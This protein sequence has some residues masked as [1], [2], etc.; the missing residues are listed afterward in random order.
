MIA[1][2]PEAG[3]AGMLAGLRRA[4]YTVEQ[5]GNFAVFDYL[6]E[7]GPQAGTT[8]RIGLEL[9][10]D[11]P[12]S[13]PH[14]PHIAPRL[15]HP[16][17]AVHTSPLG[18]EWGH[19]SRFSCDRPWPRAVLNLLA[20]A[21]LIPVV[22]GGIAVDARG[23]RLRGAEWRAH[24]A[25]PGRACMECLGQYDPAYVQAERD[26]SLDDPPTSPA[27]P[28]TIRCAARRTSSS[29]PPVPRPRS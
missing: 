2:M 26:G 22:D 20:Y 21:R 7:V 17:G 4:G 10:S 25:A 16:H 27:C 1:V 13:A 23:G 3:P 19:W 15:G 9:V 5:A 6:V 18:P 24:T 14:G 8:L 11:W 12:V 29:S 28:P